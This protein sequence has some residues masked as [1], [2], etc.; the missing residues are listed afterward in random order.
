M[1]PAASRGY[2]MQANDIFNKAA[3]FLAKNISDVELSECCDANTALSNYCFKWN[4][5]S[6]ATYQ[7]RHY[8]CLPAR[9][10]TNKNS[11]ESDINCMSLIGSNGICVRPVGD[12]S[13]QLVRISHNKGEPV[14]YVGSVKELLQ[15]SK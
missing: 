15:S 11:C 6:N 3:N 7:Q 2:C 12:N 1:D 13:T 4:D 9:S 10:V 8:A 5:L 14:L